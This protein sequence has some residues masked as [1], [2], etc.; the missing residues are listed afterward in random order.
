MAMPITVLT[1][2]RASAPAPRA[3]S[4]IPTRSVTLGLSLAHRGRA[5]AA[6]ASTASAVADGEWANTSLRRST[7]GQLRL[8]STARTA[9]GAAASM[10]A[11][12]A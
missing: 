7:L 4:A 6:V 11:A 12:L 2:V 5:Q 9:A 8:T 10:A 3:A 1:K